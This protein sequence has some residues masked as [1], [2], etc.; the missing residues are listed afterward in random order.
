MRAE[1]F[2][3]IPH[4]FSMLR[5]FRAMSYGLG[6]LGLLPQRLRWFHADVIPQRGKLFHAS[7]LPPDS[8]GS[9]NETV[10]HL[11]GECRELRGDGPLQPI[12]SQPG[13]VS[14]AWKLHGT[15]WPRKRTGST[16]RHRWRSRQLIDSGTPRAAPEFI[17]GTLPGN[18]N[19]ATD[20]P[21]GAVRHQGFRA[22]VLLSSPLLISSM[23]ASTARS[24]VKCLASP[25]TFGPPSVLGYMIQ[26][27]IPGRSS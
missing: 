12:A 6:F 16:A 7:T 2:S 5:V 9:D 23:Q 3:Q 17:A 18:H 4:P 19:G 21:A 20:A 11:P 24:R 22:Y 25:T 27:H 10:R 13:I 15:R 26:R 14:S 8:V 1:R